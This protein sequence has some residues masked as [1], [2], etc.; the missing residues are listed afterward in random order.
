MLKSRKGFSLI[1]LMIVV[2][3]IGILVAIAVPNFISMQ[4]RAKEGSVKANMHSFQ[5]AMEDYAVQNDGTYATATEKADVKALFPGGTWPKN[6][7]T[8]SAYADADVG[9]GADPAASG[10]MAANPAT[11]TSYTIKGYGKSAILALTLTNGS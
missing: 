1:E 10:D 5:L 7:F 11:T 6:P 8:G 2:V 4:N 3:I 9:F